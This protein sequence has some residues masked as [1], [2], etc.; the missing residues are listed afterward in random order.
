M[1]GDELEA[2]LDELE[3]ELA[4]VVR[5][6]LDATAVDFAAAVEDATELTA[7]S[8]SVSRIADFWRR[9][10]G[11]IMDRLR[12]IAGRSAQ[13]TADELGE[14][15]PSAN[16][17]DDALAPYMA[18]TQQLVDAVGDTLAERAAAS[19]AE[20]VAADESVDELKARLTALFAADGPQLGEY[21][22]DRIAM[23]EATRAFNAG[24]LASA[25]A[26]TGPTRPLVKQWLTR[27]DERVR[28]A[29]RDA[30]GQLQ[31]LG[32]P[33]DVGGTPVQYPGDPAA[34]LSLTVNCRCIL[35]MSAAPSERTA[36]MNEPDPDVVEELQSRMPPQ[37]KAYWLRGPGAARIRWGTPG[38]FRRCVR[39]LRDDFPQNPEGL[40]ANLYHE[41]TGRWPG[42]RNDGGTD[43]FEQ[44]PSGVVTWSTPGSTALAFENQ[45]T[46]DGRMFVPGAL[47]WDEPGPW[48]LMAKDT[49]SS[50][51]DADLA[52]AI[53]T[54]GRDGDRITGDGVLYLS[55]DA[56][57]SAAMLLSQ[58]APLGVSVDLD[59]VAMELVDA[60]GEESFSAKLVTASL[61]P[62]PDGGFQLEGVT[63]PS[64]TAAS[65]D[66]T[67]VLES[68][69][70]TFLVGPDGTVPAAA[71]EL[72]AAAGD[73]VE[74]GT[75]VDEQRSGDML[76]RITRARVRGATLVTIPAYAEARI[77]LDDQG[78]YD[79]GTDVAASGE[80]DDIND[81]QRVLRYARKHAGPVT[82]AEVAK[83][84][85]ISIMRVRR[86]LADAVRKGDLVRL[87]RGKYVTPTTGA[88]TA[89]AAADEPD[90][91]VA[92]VTGTVDLPV[93]DRDTDWDGDGAARRVFEWADGDTG[94]ISRA[95]AWR[96]DDADPATQAAYKLGYADVLD[97]TLTIVP[98]GVFA[99][100]AAM[101][102]ARGG[103]DLPDDERE[104][105]AE[106]L[107]AVRAHVDEVTGEG[108]MDE[109]E[110]SA[111]TALQDLPAMPAAWFAEPTADEL[112]PGGPGVNHA[113]GRIF[114][115]VA[116]AGE[117]HAGFAKK[118]TVD[119]LGAID[120]THFLRQRFTLDDGSVVKAGAFTMNAGHHRDGA[121]C[122]TSACQFDD[123]RTVAG[124]VTV[125]M[126]ERGMWFSGAAAPWLSEWD[127]SVFMATQPSYHMKKTP[128]GW[129]LRAVLAVP[130]PGHSSPLLASA[131]VDRSQMALTAAAAMAPPAQA[132]KPEPQHEQADA[133]PAVIDY[134]RLADALVAAMGRADEKKANDAAELESLL[135]EARTMGGNTGTEGN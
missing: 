14:Q 3:A 87:T 22:S 53:H 51:D 1:T 84:L 34:P 11:G 127:R 120:T 72:E 117:P 10:T 9:H 46:G 134:D 81:Y 45:Q 109:M 36:S 4:D 76:M 125:G 20:G 56:G 107:A 129:Q 126:S 105:V 89:S 60:S 113:N 122:E 78:M 116:Q 69:T 37:L 92:A 71:F 12:S 123:T 124:I 80:P 16:E 119:G 104:G 86:H 135:A 6:A 41:A 67:V 32:D 17:L 38:S 91:L 5:E 108:A 118:L 100:Q 55:Q 62:L 23:T 43:G 18:T 88:A 103:V 68:S 99:A 2:L 66:D 47:V 96:D 15:P 79:E 49:F 65:D 25:E 106:K 133:V 85:K 82:A 75:V 42:E 21:R 130:V 13:A 39:E 59:D 28:A 31:L 95:F 77:I 63:A 97:G 44:A 35:R 101:E 8:F 50:H 83:F 54:L 33:F 64:I 24:A 115:W 93:A 74:G 19:L 132:A 58:G 29:H 121:E 98:R 27:N 102:G 61:L 73:P 111:W 70:M 40:C 52:G 128:S 112:P 7:A 90:E 114:G 94:R 131:V 30:N 48:P 110:A 57:A 26:L